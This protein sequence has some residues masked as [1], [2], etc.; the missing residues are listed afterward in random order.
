MRRFLHDTFSRLLFAALAVTVALVFVT[1]NPAAAQ[2]M[3]AAQAPAA[4]S[5]TPGTPA[6]PVPRIRIGAGD[7]LAVTVFDVP[8]LTQALRVDDTG[9]ATL[10][11]IGRQH[12]AGLTTDEAQSLIARQLKEE[13]YIVDPQVSVLIQEYSTQGVSV[14]GEV[15]KPGMY[16]VLGNQGIL[17]VVAEAGGM[18]EMAGGEVTLRRN[19]TEKTIVMQ[20]ST[21]NRVNVVQDVQLQPGDK[22]IVPRAGMVYVIGDVN[23]PGGFIMQTNGN[24]SLLQ[25]VA[26]AAGTTP[27]SALN[28]S[29]LIRRTESGYTEIPLQLKQIMKGSQA[30]L[31]LTAED[32]VVIPSSNT[33][34]FVYQGVPGALQAAGVAAVCTVHP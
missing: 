5:S 24:M 28:S 21:G 3:P 26:M 27:T 29:R 33:K 11:L 10:L 6:H 19:G 32:I 17:D 31:S 25:A 12:L 8:E 16:P 9:D 1:I 13:S 22:V 14:V 18:T 15:K 23:R 4:Q 20:F 30:D 2:A 34:R 7:L